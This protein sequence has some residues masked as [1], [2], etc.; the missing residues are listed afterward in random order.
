[1]TSLFIRTLMTLAALGC[2]AAGG[3]AESVPA[4]EPSRGQLLYSIHCIECHNTQIHWRA[5]KQ[6]RDWNSL[7]LQV[8]R[9]QEAGQLGWTEADIDEVARYL[10]RTIYRFAPPPVRVGRS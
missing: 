4:T 5:R 10:N 8:R 1:M 6:A 3:A 7:K 2:A 9:W